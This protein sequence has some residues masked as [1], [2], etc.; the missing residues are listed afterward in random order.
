MAAGG[1]GIMSSC[2]RPEKRNSLS[3]DRKVVVDP[4]LFGAGIENLLKERG[5]C[6]RF[7]KNTYSIGGRMGEN[8][9]SMYLQFLDREHFKR[10][11][12]FR[13]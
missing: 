6:T 9:A 3:W 1:G 2:W 13:R 7:E 12:F 4:V 5:S 10:E 11:M 8:V